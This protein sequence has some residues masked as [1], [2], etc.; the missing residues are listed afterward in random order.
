MKTN[1]LK[2]L[3]FAFVALSMFSC[4]KDLLDVS[5]IE[6]NRMF[7][8]MFRQQANTGVSGDPKASQVV[9]KNDMY[10]TW[11]AIEG[12]AGYRIKMKLQAGGSWDAP[13]LDTVVG[14][15]VLK[16]TI[17]DLQY[18]TTHNFA[19]QVLS[20]K[21][22]L[23]NSKWY[24]YGDGS[25]N[26]DRCEYTMGARDSVPDVISIQSITKTSMRIVFDLKVPTAVAQKPG[27]SFQQ[28]NGYFVMDQI[29]V[30]PSMT[31][32]GLPSQVFDLTDA[33]KA[34][35]YID[36]DG[37]TSNAVYVINGVNNN[38]K[39]YWD[40]LYNTQVIRMK[41][42]PGQPILI[43]HIVDMSAIAIE[44]KASRLDTILLKYMSDNTLAEGTV[45][46]LEPGKVYYI[47]STV[48]ISKGLTLKSADPNI[49]AIVWMGLGR[50]ATND[51][52]VNNFG[53]GRNPYSG[54]IGGINIQSIIFDNISFDA[55]WAF[56]YMDKPANKTS[57]TGN[58]FINQSSGA[59]PFVCESFEVRNCE[60]R[61]MIRGWVRIQ[62]PN[63]K[64]I[65]KIVVDNCL[66]SECGAYDNN[67]RGYPYFAGDGNNYKSNIFNNV[68]VSNSTFVDSPMDHFFSEPGNLA[69]PATTTWNINLIN[70][71]FINWSTR[72]S[73]RYLFNMRYNPVN[74]KFTV[75]NNLFILTKAA[76]DTR[77][78]YM[79]GMDIRNFAGVVF[80]VDNNY[81][82]NFSLTNGQIFTLNGF[83]STSQGA[84][85]LAGAQNVGGLDATIVKL[86]TNPI[87]PTD[88]MEDPNPISI[89]G[90]R[91]HDHNLDGLYYKNTDAVKNSDI[92][93]NNIGDPRW[94]K[95][96]TP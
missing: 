71:T 43:P 59:M 66:F 28:V 16:M 55:P 62:G 96:V 50:N 70:N 11:Y 44:N 46:L 52:Y 75:K 73:G 40:R 83:S 80:D 57:G 94:R 41:G 15:D 76:G 24:G 88:L 86:G 7:M 29:K 65:E 32:P 39:R 53:F 90:E 64:F 63:R 85:Y 20:P 93:K 10:L 91:M 67:G 74:S 38:I 8:T 26:D 17:E 3:L 45:F 81:S 4:Q 79:S 49:K 54:E 51:A 33:D 35:G 87:T 72:S 2:T 27:V 42:D 58:Y 14:P 89:T 34:R 18:S 61:R 13:M 22:T 48:G 31:N 25:H 95:N 5:D 69:W 9:N 19:I 68:T 36:V 77:S 37:L 23:Y 21:D 30:E 82:T 6:K 60:F 92:F 47:A 84:G 12:A 56:N 1:I 78:L